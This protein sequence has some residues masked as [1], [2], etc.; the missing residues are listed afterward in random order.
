M[1]AMRHGLGIAGTSET[2]LDLDSLFN[3]M[4]CIEVER[5]SLFQEIQEMVRKG[6]ANKVETMLRRMS[7]LERYARRCSS[8]LRKR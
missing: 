4:M 2:G 6:E 7:A 1:N 8:T 3:R 5:A